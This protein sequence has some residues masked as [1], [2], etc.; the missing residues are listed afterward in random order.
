M[1]GND[2]DIRRLLSP[3]ATIVGSEGLGLDIGGASDRDIL[4]PYKTQAGYNRIVE[5]LKDNGFGLQESAYNSRKRDGYKVYSYKDDNHDVDV[6]I[7]RGGNAPE[8]A[9]FVRDFKSN[10][11]EDYRQSLRD[12]KQKA[13]DAWFFRDYRYKKA[14]KSIDNEIGI[15]RFHE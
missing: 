10:T 8:L 14:K 3:N 2:S 7:V 5:K 12:R 13:S 11:S 9:Q 4:V 1:H 6:A 15:T